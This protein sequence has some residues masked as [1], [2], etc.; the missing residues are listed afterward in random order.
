MLAG[1]PADP[2]GQRAVTIWSADGDY[3][4]ADE[5]I[6]GPCDIGRHQSA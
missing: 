2:S 5:G 4:A 6:A 3:P 1:D